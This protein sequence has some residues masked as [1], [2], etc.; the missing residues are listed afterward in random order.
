MYR[1]TPLRSLIKTMTW[2]L[3]ATLTT[4]SLVWLMTGTLEMALS[5]GGM[6]FVAKLVLYF[7]HERAW[8]RLPWGRRP[9][10]SA[11]PALSSCS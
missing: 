2:R 1:E 7:I 11:R 9:E 3:L 5:V 6:E 10:E 4:V 8:Q